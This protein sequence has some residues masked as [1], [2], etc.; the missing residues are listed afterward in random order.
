MLSL[1]CY[2]CCSGHRHL[3]FLATEAKLKF[4]HFMIA[5]QNA[6]IRALVRQIPG[7]P[8]LYANKVN[9][10]LETPSEDSKTF[11]MKVHQLSFILSFLL[12]NYVIQHFVVKSNR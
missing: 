7:V 5:T 10:V 4:K 9:I 8:I 6:K 11:N 3:E 2:I 12:C 1:R